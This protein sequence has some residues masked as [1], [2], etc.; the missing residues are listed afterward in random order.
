[1]MEGLHSLLL[2]DQSFYPTLFDFTEPW[3][4]DILDFMDQN[5]MYDLSMEEIA[6]YTGRSL[7]TFKRD[8]K[9]VSDLPPEKWLVRG[10]LQAAQEMLREKD[11][12]VTDVYVEVGF[13]NFSHFSSAFKRQ[14]GIAPSNYSG[15]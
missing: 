11:K 3:K 13:K 4:I 9:K 6:S 1:M 12:S 15:N 8:F 14:Y 2:I 5:Y 7:S 10:R